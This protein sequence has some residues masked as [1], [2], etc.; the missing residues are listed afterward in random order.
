M[1]NQLAATHRAFY[2]HHC[3]NLAVLTLASNYSTHNV[4]SHQLGDLIE[5]ILYDDQYSW[6]SILHYDGYLP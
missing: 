5:L 4:L 3:A 6:I 1:M 2:R